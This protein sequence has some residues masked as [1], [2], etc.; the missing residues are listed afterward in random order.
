MSNAKTASYE[1][2]TYANLEKVALLKLIGTC[3]LI[4]YLYTFNVDKY[5]KCELDR[6]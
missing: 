3:M 6:L 1:E 5:N 2:G 4:I